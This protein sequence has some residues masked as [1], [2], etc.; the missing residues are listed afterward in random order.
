M[1]DLALLTNHGALSNTNATFCHIVKLSLPQTRVVDQAEEL[2]PCQSMLPPTHAVIYLPRRT[3]FAG[4][5]APLPKA[6]NDI[7]VASVLTL[8][9]NFGASERKWN[10]VSRP[11]PR[12]VMLQ[13]LSVSVSS[14]M[15][16]PCSS[17]WMIFVQDPL[18]T[19][20]SSHSLTSLLTQPPR[21]Q[22]K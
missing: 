14:G 3:A 6:E 17:L 9:Q 2:L 13:P 18:A 22:E 19:R 15:A 4:T 10:S 20:E 1:R 11:L 8:E 21:W 7:E 16:Y 12:L 5:H